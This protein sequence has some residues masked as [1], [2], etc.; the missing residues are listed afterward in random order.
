MV[1]RFARVLGI[2]TPKPYHSEARS[3]Q[4]LLCKD[5]SLQEGAA[6]AYVM[7]PGEGGWSLRMGF[8]VPEALSLTLKRRK[9]G[10]RL[11]QKWR[12]DALENNVCA[13]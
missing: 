10:E 6:M 8:S 5:L 7:S 12:L 2:L 9:E 4:G 3:A 13:P 1:L 11:I